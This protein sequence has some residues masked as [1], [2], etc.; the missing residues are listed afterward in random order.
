MDKAPA[1]FELDHWYKVLVLAGA[2][3]V[4]GAL[5]FDLGDV[6]S[7]HVLLLALGVFFVGLGE[8]VNHPIQTIVF[9]KTRYDPIHVVTGYPRHPK[10][11]GTLFD[12]LGALLVGLAIY[13]I[14]QAA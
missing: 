2:A 1:R 8:W 3:G 6:D 4:A 13:K 12:L 11:L 5:A 14:A 7:R 9:Q 10:R